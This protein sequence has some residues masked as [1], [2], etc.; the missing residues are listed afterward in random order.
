[1]NMSG[2]L[3]YSSL[4]IMFMCNFAAYQVITFHRELETCIENHFNFDDH[5]ICIYRLESLKEKGM[6]KGQE[7][8]KMSNRLQTPPEEKPGCVPVGTN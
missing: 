3:G 4:L 6:M 2:I 1:M 7:K 8:Y 5:W